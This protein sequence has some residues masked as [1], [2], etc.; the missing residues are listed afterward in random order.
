[1]KRDNLLSEK[2]ESQLTKNPIPQKGRVGDHQQK[3]AYMILYAF[4][5]ARLNS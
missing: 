4:S 3:G 1:M 2:E 5:V